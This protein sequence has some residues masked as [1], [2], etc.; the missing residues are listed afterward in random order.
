MNVA[1]CEDIAARLAAHGGREVDDPCQADLVLVN[2]CTVRKKAED[3]AFSYLGVLK[4]LKRDGPAH[5]P[6]IAAMG[7]VV[8]GGGVRISQ[9]FPHVDLLIDYS[10]PDLVLAELSEHFAPLAP[11]EQ[12]LPGGNSECRQDAGAPRVSGKHTFVTAIR[13]CDHLCSYCVVPAAR[14]PQRD[15][16]LSEVV[17]VA[18]AHERSGEPDIAVLGQNIL[19]YGRS[20]GPGHP[21]FSELMETLLAQTSFPWITF[22]TSLAGDL[23]DEMCERV[24]AQ[25]RI[26]PLLHLPLQSGSD[27]V[28]ADMRRGY[29]AAHYRRM[30]AKARACRPD[31][32]L[33]TDLLTGFPTETEADFR[34]MLAFAAE[35]GFDDAFMF[36][37]SE[38][39]GTHAAQSHP[40]RLSRAEKMARLSELIARQRSISAERHRRFIGAELPVIIEH[41]A[42]PVG[43]ALAPP[44]IGGNELPPTGS[45]VGATEA[46]ARTAFNKI[47][48]LPATIRKPG[49]YSRVRITAAKVSSF[50]GEEIG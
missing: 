44:G 4:A 1:D 16:P 12:G 24:I 3:K 2:T 7:C 50:D 40:D 20:S 43:G 17:T 15:V 39:P 19:A 41:T 6:Y 23:T 35:I 30:V 48:R 13:G 47:V 26:T 14:G 46:V 36:A 11:W 8:P 27:R 34:E 22:L 25:P 45:G 29:T 38:R 31:L 37:Y 9:A 18:Q 28:L 49:E 10:D 32:Y 21:G 5:A 33:T 42:L